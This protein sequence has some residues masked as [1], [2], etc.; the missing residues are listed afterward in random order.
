MAWEGSHEESRQS[1]A[2][3]G[4]AEC[5]PFKAMAFISEGSLSLRCNLRLETEDDFPKLKKER[6]LP[7]GD[8]FI[9]FWGLFLQNRKQFISINVTE[10]LFFLQNK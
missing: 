3:E 6:Q 5:S 1:A 10:A 2:A 9:L 4:V 8:F 7:T